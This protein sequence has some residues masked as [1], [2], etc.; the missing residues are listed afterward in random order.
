MRRT[1][2]ILTVLAGAAF[3]VGC[4]TKP[5]PTGAEIH[6][7][8]GVNRLELT[9]PWRA[10]PV[11]TNVPQDN[12]LAAFEDDQLDALVSEAIANNPDLRVASVK[13][14]QSAEYIALARAALRP[15]VNLLGT[16]GLNMG[17]GDVSSAL[18]GI[19]LGAAWEPDL[20]GRLRYARNAARE[21]YAS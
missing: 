21:G 15:T 8:S 3:V 11:S 19:S 2:T 5:P 14:Q 18:Q 20:W 6:Q 16:G 1:K 10:A 17:G 4:K 13:V 7:Q 9:R 12:W